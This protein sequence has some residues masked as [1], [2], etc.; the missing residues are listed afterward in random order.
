MKVYDIVTGQFI[1]N[2]SP[3]YTLEQVIETLKKDKAFHL[4]IIH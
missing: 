4:V 2:V 1:A 3:E